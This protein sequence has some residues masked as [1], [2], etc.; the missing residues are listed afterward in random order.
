MA[1]RIGVADS[2]SFVGIIRRR[3]GTHNARRVQ[4][5]R[6]VLRHLRDRY[7][8][9]VAGAGLLTDEDLFDE[10]REHEQVGTALDRMWP[11]L[12]PK[13]LLHDLFGVPRLLELATRGILSAKERDALARDGDPALSSARWTPADLPL[14]DDAH[15][16]LGRLRRRRGEGDDDLF[17]TYGHIV[18]DEAQDL[19][20][21]QLRMLAR[22]SLGSMTIVGDLA[23]ATGWW[24]PGR[25]DDIVAALPTPRGARVTELTVNY[26]TP[27]EIMALAG[28]VLAVAAPNLT[29]PRS[30]RATGDHP[31]FIA[32][33]DGDLVATIV[34]RTRAELTA[35]GEGTIAVI[36][37]VDLTGLLT[38][39]LRAAGIVAGD[40]ERDG[41]EQPVTVIS[42]EMA[43][44][45]EFDAVVAAEPGQLVRESAQGLRGLYV[46][47]TRA[48]RRL[49]IVHAE[50]LPPVLADRSPGP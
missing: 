29:L 21:M 26:R 12:T 22:R 43:K 4:L 33:P 45:L 14:L 11:L 9:A 7:R 18:I 5:E 38:D 27:E 47:F 1:L 35:I 36:A 19:S 24:A 50:P 46:A 49:T 20:P 15:E 30:V 3:R 39:Q 8:S 25:W 2:Q 32:A 28:D 6:L 44:G 34:D 16:L 13:R 37:P 48:T 42:L 41:I 17:Q 10:L 40:A 23:Q 31:V